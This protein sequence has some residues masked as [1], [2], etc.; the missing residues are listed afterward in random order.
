[1]KLMIDT[2]VLLDVLLDR[3]PYSDDSAIVWRLCEI[4]EVDGFISSLS[5]ANI[6]YVLRKSIN[7]ESIMSMITDLSLIF[8][9]EDLNQGDLYGAAACKWDD[10]EDAVQF[11]T[12]LRIKADCIITRNKADYKDSIIPVMTPK[13]FLKEYGIIMESP[14]K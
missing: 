5:F 2:N 6:V 12:A 3:K 10:Y 4:K 1:M 11:A 7:K 13:D 14:D 9:F 8:R